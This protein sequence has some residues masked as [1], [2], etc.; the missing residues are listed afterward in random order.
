[1]AVM[2][3]FVMT[4]MMVPVMM[5][6]VVL[7]VMANRFFRFAG[8]GDRDAGDRSQSTANHRAVASAYSRAYGCTGTSADSASQHCI[9]RY[10]VGKGVISGPGQQGGQQKGTKV[11]HLVFGFL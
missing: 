3:V 9:R 8:G 5:V 7:V 2:R 11:F 10:L 4:M 6:G 1:M